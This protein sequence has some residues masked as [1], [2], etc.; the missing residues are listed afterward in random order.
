MGVKVTFDGIN[1]I[2][3]VDLAPT[4]GEVNIDVQA[5]LY[6]DMKEDWRSDALLNKLRP[7]IAVI[8]GQST[9]GSDSA[10]DLYFLDSA[11]KIK[12]YEGNHRLILTG[13]IFSRDGT[14]VF[15][16][17]NGVFQVLT[18]MVVSSLVTKVSTGS[19]VN[20]QDVTDIA[21]KTRAVIMSTEN[22]AAGNPGEI[23]DYT[24]EAP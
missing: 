19:G 21:N 6:S 22:Q 23:R 1:K 18:E 12:P 16:F 8:G 13:S 9:V 20:A 10:G 7:P 5:D 11:W 3:I 14:S 24:P 15:T 2:I 4:S 17:T